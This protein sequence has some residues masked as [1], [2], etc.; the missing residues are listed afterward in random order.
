[1]KYFF[2]QPTSFLVIF[3][4]CQLN[5]IPLVL[6]SYPGRL[7]SRNTTM[8]YTALWSQSQSNITADGQSYSKSW[9]RAPFG[10]HDQI[11]ITVWQLRS[12]FC[13]ALLSDERAGLSCVHAAGSSQ[14]SLS[15]VPW[16][17]R[18]YF[19]RTGSDLRLPFSSPPTTRRVTVEVF[20]PASKRVCKLPTQSQVQVQ[21]TLRLTVGQSVSKSWCRARLGLM[22]RYLLLLTV[23]GLCFV[24]RPLWREDRYAI[25]T[26]SWPLPGQS[27]S[28]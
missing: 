18:P 26:F 15:R 13:G 16:Y 28:G 19:T 2:S 20:D 14:R 27:F 5:S 1:M 10:A 23:M 21:V 4:N 17:S 6:N 8:F 7:A 22:T 24:G 25:C 3:C 12:R 11:C 9:C